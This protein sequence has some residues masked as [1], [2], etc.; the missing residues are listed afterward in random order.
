MALDSSR[1]G[2]AVADAVQAWSSANVPQNRITFITNSELEDLWMVITG[3][4]KT[5]LNN[6]QDIDLLASDIKV[7]P[8]TFK[9]SL[10][11]PITG[12]GVSEAVTLT[13][14]TK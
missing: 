1:W 4:H 6:H 3:Q 10:T 12:V 13:Q 8:G 11:N 2:P 7:D 9:D 14:R 5:E